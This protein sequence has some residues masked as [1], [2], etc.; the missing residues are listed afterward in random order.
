MIGLVSGFLALVILAIICGLIIY[1]KRRRRGRQTDKHLELN[2]NDAKYNSH[3]YLPLSK[4][5]FSIVEMGSM[6][7][8]SQWGSSPHS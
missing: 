5:P 6:Q 4:V 7:K 8:Q 2:Y 1:F 3:V